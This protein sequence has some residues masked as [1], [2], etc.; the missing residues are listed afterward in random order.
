M[1]AFRDK[2]TSEDDIHIHL[3]LSNRYK[4]KLLM[5]LLILGAGWTSTFLIPLCESTHVTY[6]ATTRSGSERTIQFTF[7]PESDDPIPYKRLPDAH[8]VLITFPITVKGGSEK[9]VK[10]YQQT[11]QDTGLEPRFIQL[12]ATSLWGDSSRNNP[13]AKLT[14]PS[15]TEWY[16]RHSPIKVNPRG[17]EE[18]ALLALSPE[19]P[20]TVLNLAGLWGG[21]RSMRNWVDKVL[22]TKEV[23]K[24]KASLHMIHGLDVARAILAVHLH[25]QFPA[26]ERWI[27]TDMRV[28]DWWD[29]S[30][31][32]SVGEG[33]KKDGPQAAWVRELMREEGVRALPRSPEQLG[34]AL[35][36]REFWEFFGLSPMKRLD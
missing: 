8:T 11:R 21:S 16:D 20:T 7:D 9:L 15:I 4:K 31:A 12:G 25:T 10:L 3:I 26:G 33:D 23:L 24:Y 17:E 13:N 22:P 18:N 14:K 1:S 29:L 2:K 28:Y 36:S 34:R 27:L 6:A 35:D 32:W 5:N 19:T 30:S